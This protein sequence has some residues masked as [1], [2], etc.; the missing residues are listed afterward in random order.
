VNQDFFETAKQEETWIVAKVD[1]GKY[2]R[3]PKKNDAGENEPL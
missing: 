3:M 2:Q 1:W